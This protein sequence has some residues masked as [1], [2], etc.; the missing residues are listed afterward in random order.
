[1][2][3]LIIEDNRDIAANI[4]DYLEPLGYELDFAMNG[5]LALELLAGARFD[6]VVLDLML[7]RVDGLEVCRRLRADLGLHTPVLMLT[8]RDQL[9]DKLAG[10][11]AGADDY[12][13]KPFSVRELA[14]RLEVLVRRAQPPPARRLQVGGLRY[15]AEQCRAE[16]DGLPLELNPT[17]RKLLVLLMQ[18]SDRVVSRQE[19]E[20]HIWGDEP[21]DRDVLRSHIY[22]LRNIIDRPFAEKLLHTVHRVGYRLCLPAEAP[23][24]LHTGGR[25]APEQTTATGAG[26]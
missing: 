24:V 9:E 26:E 7:P 22:A 18:H 3:L 13:V 16:R 17:Q 5:D 19:I 25:H 4:A 15:D 14:A 11:A 1:M 2:R 21:P 12:L 20:R 6:A 8:A 10:F 23:R